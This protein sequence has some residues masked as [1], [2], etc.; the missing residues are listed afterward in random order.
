MS[1]A[2]LTFNLLGLRLGAEPHEDSYFD[3][4]MLCV[5]HSLRCAGFKV[6]HSVNRYVEGAINVVWGAGTHLF[7]NLES[8]RKVA[9]PS[10]TVIF[11]MEQLGGESPLLT[12]GYFDFLSDYVVWDYNSVNFLHA[13]LRRISPRGVEF[14]VSPCQALADVDLEDSGGNWFDVLFYGARN[15]RRE[16]LVASLVER[17]VRVGWPSAF[18]RNLAPYLRAS[19]LV[20]NVHAYSTAVF[21][22]TRMLRPVAMGVP[23]VSEISVMPESVDWTKSG[24]L[25]AEYSNLRDSC[26][27]LLDDNR[28]QLRMA[29]RS[30]AFC[31]GTDVQNSVRVAVERTLDLLASG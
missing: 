29:R 26:I 8:V 12:S 22:M 30:I 10:G 11:N 24:I 18:G 28:R 4:T 17:G 5:A 23:V 16:R 7:P 15:E 27:A 21:E 2:E 3:E 14:P 6:V 1:S 9:K 13:G 31:A 20:L 19:A 25:F